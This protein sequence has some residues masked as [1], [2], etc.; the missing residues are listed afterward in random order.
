MRSRARCW[1]RSATTCARRWRRSASPP[2]RCWIPRCTSPTRT[3]SASA[4]AIDREAEYLN[5]LVTNLLDLSRIEG[6][7]LRADREASDTADLVARTLERMAPRLQGRSLTVA[8][9]HELPP[10][11]VD[12]V[13]FDQVLTNLIE[14]EVKYVPSD[15][16][17]LR[18]GGDRGR[19]RRR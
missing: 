14:N 3:E 4:Q 7:A 9:P 6:G 1:S 10:V 19:G 5:R 18:P 12:A 15:R 11:L 13:F 8:V 2:A 16:H 17:I